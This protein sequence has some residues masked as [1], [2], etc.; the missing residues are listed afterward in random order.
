MMLKNMRETEN[1]YQKLN[2]EQQNLLQP[3]SNINWVDPNPSHVQS[4]THS[5]FNISK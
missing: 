5:G 3:S 4:I 1:K 2:E